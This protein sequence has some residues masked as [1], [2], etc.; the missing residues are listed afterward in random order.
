MSS[1]RRGGLQRPFHQLT[2]VVCR[3]EDTSPCRPRHPTSISEDAVFGIFESC[4]RRNDSEFNRSKRRKQSREG[5]KYQFWVKSRRPP[6]GAPGFDRGFEAKLLLTL[7]VLS[8][9]LF[10]LNRSAFLLQTEIQLA[11][12]A[13]RAET[14]RPTLARAS[15]ESSAAGLAALRLC[16][17]PRPS[18]RNG[19]L[20]RRR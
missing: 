2:R 19:Q 5:P 12:S 10:Q 4:S 13:R 3:R 17:N 20:R 18:G 16:V 14:A 9:R 15:P 8:V 11:I 6:N 7:R 1:P